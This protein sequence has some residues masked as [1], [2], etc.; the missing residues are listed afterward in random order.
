MATHAI[1]HKR[2]TA[3]LSKFICFVLTINKKP[4]ITDSNYQLAKIKMG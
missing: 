3:Q 1:T 2:I 4:Q